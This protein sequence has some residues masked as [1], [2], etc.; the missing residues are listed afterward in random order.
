MSSDITR[1]YPWYLGTPVPKPDPLDNLYVEDM[2][3]AVIW[4]TGPNLRNMMEDLRR[5]HGDRAVTE[6]FYRFYH[7]HP[8]LGRDYLHD[9]REVRQALQRYLAA[10]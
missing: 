2:I 8:R 4:S 10:K 1:K 6:S 3:A 5:K 7:E 9:G